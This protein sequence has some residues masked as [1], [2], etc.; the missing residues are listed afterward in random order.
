MSLFWFKIRWSGLKEGRKGGRGDAASLAA[1]GGYKICSNNWKPNRFP[2]TDASG[3]L[4][5]PS[6]SAEFVKCIILLVLKFSSHLF[7]GEKR[8]Q[9]SHDG[10]PNFPGLNKPSFIRLL[11]PG[12][13]VNR[14]IYQF[15]YKKKKKKGRKQKY[16]THTTNQCKINDCIRNLP[17]VCRYNNQ[18]WIFLWQLYHSRKL[19]V[20]NNNWFLLHCFVSCINGKPGQKE[21]VSLDQQ[22]QW[23]SFDQEMGERNGRTISYQLSAVLVY[24]LV[25]F[26]LTM[27]G[28]EDLVTSR[29]TNIRLKQIRIAYSVSGHGGWSS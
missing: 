26:C 15:L 21:R 11:I 28:A 9:I 6:L 13:L 3:I 5:Y 10:L 22:L 18:C 20:N 23:M 19:W 25:I 7:A 16:T 14:N 17:F 12:L 1:N 8:E 29:F 24:L 4:V 27:N 2:W